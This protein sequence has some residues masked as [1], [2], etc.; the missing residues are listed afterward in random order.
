MSAYSANASVISD[1]MDI[2]SDEIG[3]PVNIGDAVLEWNGR[4]LQKIAL[5]Q[6]GDGTVQSGDG[7]KPLKKSS[8]EKGKR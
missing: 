4:Q 1:R 7:T 3:N 2:E 6:S 8:F 5:E